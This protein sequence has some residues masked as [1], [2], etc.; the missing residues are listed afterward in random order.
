MSD[1]LPCTPDDIATQA[2]AAAEAGATILPLLAR[3]PTDEDVSINPDDFA[4]F[5][6]CVKQATGA[7]L[8]IFT[9]GSPNNT[10]EE[11]IAPAPRLSPEMCNLNMG[12]MNFCFLPRA[13]RYDPCK[14][15]LEKQSV[16]NSDT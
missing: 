1:A 12:S 3:R 16:E 10:I 6:S 11:R 8:N 7:V 13:K 2:I 14:L 4:A 5:L 15:D 9:G